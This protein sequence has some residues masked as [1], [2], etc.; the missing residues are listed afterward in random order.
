MARVPPAR[1]AAQ[2]PINTIKFL[3]CASASSCL[4]DDM[5]KNESPKVLM[6]SSSRLPVERAPFSPPPPPPPPLGDPSAFR[7]AKVG[8]AKEKAEWGAYG[9]APIGG[10]RTSGCA[11]RHFQVQDDHFA[12]KFLGDIPPKWHTRPDLI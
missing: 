8:S 3:F 6:D 11:L 4:P 7:H 12:W 9:S 10:R 5:R 1:T 2:R